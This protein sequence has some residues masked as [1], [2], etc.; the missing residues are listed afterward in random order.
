[1]Q[2]ELDNSD[3][4]ITLINNNMIQSAKKQFGNRPVS[5]IIDD[6]VINKYYDSDIEGR[7][8]VYSSD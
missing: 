5:L 4:K 1:M 7:D 8:I 3:V 6:T 2:R